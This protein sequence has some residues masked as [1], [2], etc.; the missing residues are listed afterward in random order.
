MK[1]PRRRLPS[2]RI[3]AWAAGIASAVALAVGVAQR[4]GDPSR[5]VTPFRIGFQDSPPYQAVTSDGKPT[6]MAIE[7]VAEACRRAQIPVVW[8]PWPSGPESALR[9]GKV[10]LW[11]VFNDLPERHRLFHITKPWLLNGVWL[12]ARK[13]SGIRSIGDTVGRSVWYQDTMMGTRLAHQKFPNSLL[14]PQSTHAAVLRGVYEGKAD[15]GANRGQPGPHGEA[16]QR[17]PCSA[18]GS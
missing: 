9:S 3:I 18:V 15:A 6:G 1:A 7:V 11:P 14:T 2:R 5:A 13:D 10:D 17:R 4:Q 16:S 12:V 8:V